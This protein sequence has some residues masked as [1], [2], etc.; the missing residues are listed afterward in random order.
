ML[1]PGDVVTAGA[2]A[3]SRE[4]RAALRGAF[5][6]EAIAHSRAVAAAGALHA[7]VFALGIERFAAVEAQR[8]ELVSSIA[9]LLAPWIDKPE[10]PPAWVAAL[11]RAVARAEGAGEH[12]AD[13]IRRLVV[14]DAPPPAVVEP[15][16][17][18]VEPAELPGDV[19]P[20]PPR[21]AGPPPEPP[22][23]AL[24][25]EGYD[26]REDPES[27]AECRRTL[28]RGDRVERTEVEGARRVR[29]EWCVAGVRE[30]PRGGSPGAR[31]GPKGPRV[32]APPAKAWE[33]IGLF[34]PRNS[35]SGT[36]G[37]ETPANAPAPTKGGRDGTT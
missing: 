16:P 25:L 5:V 1:T 34:A 26:W 24:A 28:V 7:S 18:E 21:P 2:R 17:V 35:T 11:R 20:A 12:A 22:S 23:R 30:K 6:R 10:S 19:A 15:P 4:E 14:G 36:A 29:C 33:A 3:L 9:E 31:R 37:G 8:D 27:C 32:T 13:G